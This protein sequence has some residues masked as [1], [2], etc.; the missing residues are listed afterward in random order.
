MAV[1][2]YSFYCLN[3]QRCE[4]SKRCGCSFFSF[5]RP[6]CCF[7]ELDVDLNQNTV[8]PLFHTLFFA[9]CVSR[10]VGEEMREKNT[11]A[12]FLTRSNCAKMVQGCSQKFISKNEKKG[13][14]DL[15]LLK[16]QENERKKN[17]C[18]RKTTK[19]F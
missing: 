11:I 18:E 17:R 12:F 10:G 2:N 9:F 7:S 8:Q 5:F 15:G 19:L 3:R 1:I 16:N 6:S 14:D 13:D 4:E